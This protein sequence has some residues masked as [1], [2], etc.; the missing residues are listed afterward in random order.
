M[1]NKSINT[2]VQEPDVTR[3]YNNFVAQVSFK[4]HTV[5]SY[6][7]NPSMVLEEAKEKGCSDPV[8]FYVPDPSIP[9]IY[10]VQT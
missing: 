4:D 8:I 9:Q 7:K 10:V 5:V 6:G 2:L 1:T 3:Y